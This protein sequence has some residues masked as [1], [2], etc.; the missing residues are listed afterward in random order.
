MWRSGAGLAAVIAV[1]GG[2]AGPPL[3][4]AQQEVSD[5][6]PSSLGAVV[7]S[8]PGLYPSRE[9]DP[10]LPRPASLPSANLVRSNSI[11]SDPAALN[12]HSARRP[13]LLIGMYVS[14]G[15]L[16]ALDAELTISALRAGRAHEGNPIL[17]PFASNPAALAAFKLVLTGGTILG[18]D[19][20]RKSHPKLAMVALTA[21]NGGYAF[22]VLRDFRNFSTR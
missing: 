1:V 4:R 21:I 3:V 10:A 16:Q 17:S 22:V 8:G 9:G 7:G 5:R 11:G 20:S 12:P 18:I 19:R 15:L 13:A 2:L 14:Y 6:S